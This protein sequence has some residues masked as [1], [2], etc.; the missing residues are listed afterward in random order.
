MLAIRNILARWI[1]APLSVMIVVTMALGFSTSTP[2]LA[3]G[4]PIV[5]GTPRFA[6]I[7]HGNLS[8][9]YT[10]PPPDPLA[11]WSS[12]FTFGGT[13]YP[14]TMVGTNPTLGSVKTIVPAI[15]VPIKLVFQI[16][17]TQAFDGT[18]RVH[19]LTQSPMFRPANF[20]SGSNIQYGDAFQ[21]AEFWNSV[22]T[23]SKSYHVL[24]SNP[25]TVAATVTINV[26]LADGSVGNDGSGHLIGLIDIGYLDSQLVP[27]L[28]AYTP[29]T[30]PIFLSDDTY[31]TQSGSCCIGGFHSAV[32]ATG[33]TYMW[34]TDSD[35]GV[36][37]GFGDDVGAFSHELGEWLN[38]PFVNNTVPN[39]VVPPT[40]GCQGNLEVGD[41][42]VGTNFSVSGYP[43][44]HLQ[45]LAFFSWF[46]RQSPSIGIKGR[47]DFTGV[48]STFSTAC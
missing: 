2:A 45:D 31:A 14:F 25:P 27:L 12:S 35:P 20:I 41:P 48:F 38:D 15:V 1:F 34:T 37:G 36:E 26:P 33:Q 4:Y 42:L 5:H 16:A 30:L 17:K 46:A 28:S 6:V 24:I 22:S 21:R 8:Q 13:T 11:T 3:A 40:G 9:P 44:Y 7:T 19:D 43:T 32:A 47:Y 39:W 10:P 18:I 23:T 29:N